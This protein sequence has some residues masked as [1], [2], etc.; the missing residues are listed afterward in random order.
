MMVEQVAILAALISLPV[1]ALL[2]NRGAV[3]PSQSVEAFAIGDRHFKMFR[4]GAG[5]SMAFVGGA[6]TLNMASLGYQYGWTVAIDPLIVFVALL[7]AVALAGK[8]R[9]GRGITLTDALAGTSAPLRM[10]LALTGFIIYQLL[11]ASQFVALGKLLGPYFP[12]VPTALVICIPA[13][14]VFGYTYVRGFQAV[15]NTDVLQLIVM[16]VFYAGASLWI[17]LSHPIPAD[18]AL[19]TPPAEPPFNLLLYLALPLLFVPV[20]YDVHLRVKAAV[21]LAHARAG[22]VIGALQYVLFLCI[23]IGI[24]VYFRY[25]GLAVDNPE[26]VL[27]RFFDQFFGSFGVIG[28]VAVLAAIVSTLDSMAF[29][30]IVSASNDVL[31]PARTKGILSD[32]KTLAIST[33]AVLALAVLIALVFQQILALVLAALLLFVSIFI[34]V[35]LGRALGVGDRLLV[36]SSLV[37]GAAIVACKLAGYVPP[38]EPFAFLGLHLLL[39]LMS[40]LVRR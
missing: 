34:P 31:G 6:A 16:L 23:S 4:L 39:V 21:S 3:S 5:I 10:T 15:T 35:S 29:N 36:S 19:A 18:V 32:R 17:F 8:V 30:T 26:N 13:A 28:T 1:V 22:L 37:T 38:V 20:S 14:V 12:D 25:T 7:I 40:K 2:A 11:T 24:G 9:A 33:V 27:P